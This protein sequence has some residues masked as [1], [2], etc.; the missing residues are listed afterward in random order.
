LKSA[1]VE[2]NQNTGEPEVNLEFDSDGAK[3]FA[4]ITKRNVGKQVAIYL[5]GTAISVP[6][7][8]QEIT[9]GN[10][11]IS[12]NFTIDE[13]KTLARRLNAG[14]LPVA[15]TLI[16][17]QTIGPSLGRISIAR[18]FFAGLIG[19]IL[20]ALFM[21]AYYRLPGLLATIALG[22]YTLLVLAIFK[23]W[24]ITLT[25]AGIAGFILSIGMAVDA[26][27]LIFERTREELR[28]GRSLKSSIDE[29]FKRAWLSIR[30]SNVSS[31]ITALILAWFGTSIIKGFAITLAIGIIVS[32]FSAITITR[33]FFRLVSG[34]WLDRHRWL[35]GPGLSKSQSDHLQ[36]E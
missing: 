18:S 29:G 35:I 16:S 9:G 3:L 10:A 31:I 22:I 30:D 19:V 34:D 14:A 8:D 17:Q 36:K 2:F 4:E 21:I 26:N 33:T 1:A 20:V 15:I 27:I 24:P 11:V 28:S 5:D 25:L 7:V 12:G 6:T 23:L 32:L 13:A